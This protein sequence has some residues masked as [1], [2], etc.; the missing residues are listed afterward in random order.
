MQE[1]TIELIYLA[2]FASVTALAPK[3]L[4]HLSVDTAQIFQQLVLL[5]N[6]ALDWLICYQFCEC[7][8]TK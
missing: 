8:E 5:R 3:E 1:G 4:C 6:P 7:V 2:A